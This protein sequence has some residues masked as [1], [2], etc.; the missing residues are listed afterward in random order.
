M[1]K[2]VTMFPILALLFLAVSCSHVHETDIGS[3]VGENSIMGILLE[4]CVTDDEYEVCKIH[5]LMRIPDTELVYAV[6]ENAVFAIQSPY[7]WEFVVPLGAEFVFIGTISQVRSW[8]IEMDRYPSVAPDGVYAPDNT[9]VVVID[10]FDKCK[11]YSSSI[12]RLTPYDHLCPK[13]DNVRFIGTWVQIRASDIID[14]ESLHISLHPRLTQGD[15]YHVRFLQSGWIP[16]TIQC[17]T[18][19]YFTPPSQI[20]VCIQEVVGDAYLA[21]DITFNLFDTNLKQIGEHVIHLH[22]PN[23]SPMQKPR[24]NEEYVIGT[25]DELGGAIA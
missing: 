21:L 3:P 20:E 25:W 15:I 17:A 12:M 9:L 18:D 24:F 22:I 5:S 10:I 11:M 14:T 7:D 19:F 23:D 2:F 8:E 6:I 1:K 13:E 16:W 4:S